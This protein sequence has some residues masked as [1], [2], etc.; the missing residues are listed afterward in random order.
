MLSFSHLHGSDLE[1]SLHKKNT[2]PKD[3]LQLADLY[4]DFVFEG[5]GFCLPLDLYNAITG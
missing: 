3:V 4:L 5:Q 2:K 1:D